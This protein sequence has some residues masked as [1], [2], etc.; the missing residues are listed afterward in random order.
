MVCSRSNGK[1]KVD[2]LEAYS[3]LGHISITVTQTIAQ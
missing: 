1:L 3:K 2:I